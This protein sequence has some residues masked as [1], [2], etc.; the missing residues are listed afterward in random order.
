MAR[1]LPSRPRLVLNIGS[2]GVHAAVAA[3]DERGIIDIERVARS[4]PLVLPE[5]NL[6][7][8]WKKLHTMT[9]DVV[10]DLRKSGSRPHSAVVIFSSPW[11]FSE[12]RRF[13]HTSE[14]PVEI[15]EKLLSAFAADEEK[16]FREASLERFHVAADEV[17]ALEPVRM[18]TILNGYPADAPVGKRART[19]E[20]FLYL[21]AVFGRAWE[22]IE[23]L[24]DDNG[25]RLAGIQTSPMAFYRAAEALGIADEG[26]VVIDVGGE[27]TEVSVIKNGILYDSVSYARGLNFV[28]RR[29]AEALS[30]DV[31]AA[32]V[33]LQ[34]Y[35]SGALED[36]KASRVKKIVGE[37]VAEWKTLLSDALEHV[38]S[39]GLLPEI[40]LVAGPG[41]ILPE[42]AEAVSADE[43]RPFTIFGRSLN[44]RRL[45]PKDFASQVAHIPSVF[46]NAELT[47][48][49]VD[50]LYSFK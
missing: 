43:F 33:Y 19:L 29:T 5:V 28:A 6:K 12:A 30:L 22:D 45:A 17:S 34:N 1:F 26:R 44:V 4:C 38:S 21:S 18:R 14:A 25:I 23:T 39:K 46:S 20:A 9:S 42:F 16:Q 3:K 48:L 8:L 49:L 27:I 11:Y 32:I 15:T 50:L 35:G 7:K 24:L 10:G 31:E 36:G 47:N 37:A 2:S 40:A 13:V 41:N